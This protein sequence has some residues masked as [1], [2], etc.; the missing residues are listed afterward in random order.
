MF[1]SKYLIFIQMDNSFTWRYIYFADVPK[2][3]T[4]RR[5]FSVRPPVRIFK[6]EK[7]LYSYY[8]ILMLD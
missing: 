1:Y 6:F 3:D 7:R 5:D 4:K 2:I 8:L